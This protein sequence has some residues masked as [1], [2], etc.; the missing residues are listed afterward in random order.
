MQ[1]QLIAAAS[2]AAAV[3]MMSG[4]T[5]TARYVTTEHWATG[6]QFYVGFTEYK[7][8]NLI[9]LRTG[10]SSAHVM[11][12]NASDTNNVQCRPQVAVDRL[13]NPGKKYEEP[14]KPAPAQVAPSE[15]ESE[16][17]GEA[18]EPNA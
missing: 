6:D 13:L 1:F 18:G 16:S 15:S 14:P 17:G 4:C 5:T 8:T 3:S 9:V 10:E 7:E 12:C 2:I 11:L